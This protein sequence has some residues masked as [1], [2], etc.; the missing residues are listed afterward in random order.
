MDRDHPH[1]DRA[2]EILALADAYVQGSLSAEMAERLEHLVLHDAEA[3]QWYVEYL[4]DSYHLHLLAAHALTDEE[5]DKG[6]DECGMDAMM[7]WATQAGI[8]HSAFIIQSFSHYPLSTVHYPLSLGSI[9][10]SYLAATVIVGVGLLIGWAWKVSDHPQ[11]A[12]QS[13]PLPS[14]LSPLP[15]VVG[16]ITGIVDCQW[17]QG[18]ESESPR[19]RLSNLN[20]RPRLSRRQ[21]HPGLRPDGNHLRHRGQSH[22]P[23]PGHVRGGIERR[24]LLIPWQVDREVG[25]EVASGQWSVASKSQTLLIPN[26]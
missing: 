25:E 23:R 21:I 14:P 6:N 24:W 22:P 10:F 3:R 2:A 9:L 13:V 1:A 15:S 8:H 16:R 7:N 20:S 17:V 18:R 26:P 5:S 4:Q 11:I 12:R 19:V